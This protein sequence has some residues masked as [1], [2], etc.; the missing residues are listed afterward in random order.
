MA[1]RQAELA[2]APVEEKAALEGALESLTMKEVDKSTK[3]ARGDEWKPEPKPIRCNSKMGVKKVMF[4]HHV[5]AGRKGK[6]AYEEKNPQQVKESVR[7]VEAML[8]A[9]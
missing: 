1:Q 6:D 7:R 8:K 9:R 4:E 5:R 3:E 2:A